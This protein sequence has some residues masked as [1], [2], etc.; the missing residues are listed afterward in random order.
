[1]DSQLTPQD[2]IN[3]VA[4]EDLELAGLTLEEALE[5]LKEQP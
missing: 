2:L 4:Q 1:M 5:L 3:L